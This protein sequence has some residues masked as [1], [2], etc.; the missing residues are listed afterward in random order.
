VKCVTHRT[1]CLTTLSPAERN[2]L[3]LVE[4]IH[5]RR[6]L[7]VPSSAATAVNIYNKMTEL[8]L[9]CKSSLYSTNR[10]VR[11]T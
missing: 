9:A 6:L 4:T 7:R 2:V 11:P 5:G 1:G 3:R 8:A 10:C